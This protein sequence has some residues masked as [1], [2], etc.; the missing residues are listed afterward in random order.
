MGLAGVLV[1]YDINRCNIFES[2]DDVLH[3]R[4]E[5]NHNKVYMQPSRRSSCLASSAKEHVIHVEVILKWN[6]VD[7]HTFF[8]LIFLL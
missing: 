8:I 1:R 7:H 4:K 5:I 3:L 6:L 2:T